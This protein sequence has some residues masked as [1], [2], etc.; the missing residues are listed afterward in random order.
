M[1][2]LDKYRSGL[3][4]WETRGRRFKSSRSDH[5]QD[6]SQ[7]VCRGPFPGSSSIRV[8]AGLTRGP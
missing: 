3:Q 8:F 7:D 4:P 2:Q 5:F 6:V 1:I